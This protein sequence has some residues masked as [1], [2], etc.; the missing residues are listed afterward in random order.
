[1]AGEHLPIQSACL[2][3][4]RERPLVTSPGL[5]WIPPMVRSMAM[6]MS[7]GPT[8]TRDRVELATIVA[9]NWPSRAQLMG[10]K[11]SRPCARSRDTPHSVQ[12][13]PPGDPRVQ[14]LVIAFW[15]QFRWS[16]PTG[17]WPSHFFMYMY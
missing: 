9:R 1:M 14:P 12:I 6:Y 13:R 11:A 4:Y 2:T 10:G 5:L 17:R 15:G 8:I 7:S 16:Y 3:M